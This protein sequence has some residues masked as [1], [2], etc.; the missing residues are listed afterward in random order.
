MKG[1]SAVEL[2]TTYSWAF[3]IIA[4]FISFVF[5]L[6]SSS[7][8]AN[9]F[10]SSCVVTPEITCQDSSLISA[11]GNTT[12]EVQ[13]H[14]NL[15]V[16]IYFPANGLTVSYGFSNTI[17]QGQ[18]TPKTVPAGSIFTCVSSGELSL[19]G[20]ESQNVH[21]NINYNICEP[22]CGITQGA[23]SS[24]EANGIK[25]SIPIKITNDYGSMNSPFQQMITIPNAEYRAYEAGNLHNIEFF[26]ANGTVIPSWLESGGSN[27]SAS[28]IYWIKLTGSAASPLPIY[29]ESTTVYMGFAA[30][31]VNL[32]NTATTGEAPQL[33]CNN[34]SNPATG[35]AAGQYGKY[36]DGANVFG[37]YWNFAGTTVPSGMTSSGT[38]TINNGATVSFGG[39]LTTT[40]TFNY[41]SN[42][43]A[44]FG[45]S[46]PTTNAGNAWY[47]FGYVSQSGGYSYDSSTAIAWNINDAPP[48]FVSDAGVSFTSTAFP[49]GVAP[50][51]SFNIGTV[52][53]GSASSDS[54]W[55]NYVNEITQTAEIPPSGLYYLGINNNQG[56]GTAPPIP[57]LYWLR[58]RTYPPSGVMPSVSIGPVS[59][60]NQAMG[61]YANYSTSGYAIEGVQQSIYPEY[62]A[63]FNGA[64]S[65]ITAN[66]VNLPGPPSPF[67]ISMWIYPNSIKKS[68]FF[69]EGTSPTCYGYFAYLNPSEDPAFGQQCNGPGTQ[70]GTV[71]STDKWYEVVGTY[72]GTTLRI[73]EDGSLAGSE[74]VSLSPY[75]FSSQLIGSAQDGYF[76]G[77]ISNVQIYNASLS[78]S[79]IKQLYTEGIGGPPIQLQNLVGW[80]LLDGNSKDYSGHQN[81]GAAYNITYAS[82]W[83]SGY[84][85]P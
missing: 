54:G 32:F 67:S 33:S 26:Y 80:W 66:V 30:A 42:I 83:Q 44:D 48:Y 82:N 46:A 74:T 22:L 71:L 21:F 31:N 70:F 37:N 28:S 3:L 77:L 49:S 72:D 34:P 14:N 1:Q 47:Q 13:L 2:L 57:T 51:G 69:Q 7:N 56:D 79:E 75:S 9:N 61:N 25:Y 65:S 68:D 41:P 38:V 15:G 50:T 5:V 53:W 73:Y 63:Q 55:I 18:C 85:P 24:L 23:I 10:A 36:D 29:G 43:I 11:A 39:Y 12:F 58:T 64:T 27:T 17:Y 59:N 60:I 6:A 40:A 4:V 62:V 76:S 84:T 16:Q 20:S 78:G 35:C 8:P 19:P 81:N 52:Y 45:F